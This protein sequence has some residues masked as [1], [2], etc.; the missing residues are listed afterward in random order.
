[1]GEDYTVEEIPAELAG[2]GRRVPR[3]LI[4][5]LADADDAIM[6][7]FLEAV[8]SPSRDRGRDP[9][10]HPG[11]QAQPGALRHGVQ[12]Q[13]RAAPARRGRRLPALAPR[14]RRDHQGHS[15]RDEDEQIS[16]KPTTSEPFSG[17]AFKIA[18]DPHLGKREIYVRVYSGKLEAG[19]TVVNSVNGRKER[20][21]K[22]HQMHANKR[23][24]SRRSAPARS[25]PSWALKD[26]KTGDTLCDP[27][28]QVV[29]ESMTFP[30][31]VIEV[32]IEPKTKSDQG[33][34]R[35]R[36]PAALRRDPTFR[37]HRRGD[38]P[39][40]HRRHGRAPPGDHRRPDEARVPRRGDR[41][42]AAGGL[43]RDHPPKVENHASYTHKKQ[44]GGSGQFAGRHL[45]RAA[46]EETGGAGYSSSTTCRWSRAAGSTS[47]PVDQGRP[48]TPWSSA[49]SPA[50]RWST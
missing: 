4:E 17:L 19:S 16:R 32:A 8:S 34:A 10:R 15:V 20:I 1:M 26:T 12:E 36:D 11:R 24:R 3:E 35:H 38:R 42:Q 22:G 44:T 46:S 27:Q 45:D 2:E 18:S 6:E 23:E 50:T 47:R 29:L 43:P 41:R 30:A 21:G 39:D 33:E 40:D 5:T 9:S 31:P 49:C 14:H 28:N 25:S 13:G 37:S 7:K 48:R